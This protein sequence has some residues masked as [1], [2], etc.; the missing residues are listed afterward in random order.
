MFVSRQ[1][2]ICRM[3][4]RTTHN[5]CWANAWRENRD[6]LAKSIGTIAAPRNANNA[7]QRRYAERVAKLFHENETYTEKKTHTQTRKSF[8]F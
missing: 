5:Q 4:A 7:R 6:A 2:M 8:L 3:L 1:F